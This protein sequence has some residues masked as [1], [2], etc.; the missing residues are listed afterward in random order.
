MMER[1]M[2]SASS[3]CAWSAGTV[4]RS[5]IGVLVVIALRGEGQLGDAA[6]AVE[7]AVIADG[8][9]A[10]IDRRFAR[11]EVIGETVQHARPSVAHRVVVRII[12][13]RFLRADPGA[14]LCLRVADAAIEAD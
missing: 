7:I 9:L 3:R 14:E 1:R 5:G 4:E 10:A 6:E 2:S 13:D 12:R 11:E 8:G